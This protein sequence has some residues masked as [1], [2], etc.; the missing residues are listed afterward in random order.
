M[1]TKSKSVLVTTCVLYIM[2]QGGSGVMSGDAPVISVGVCPVGQPRGADSLSS[3]LHNHHLPALAHSLCYSVCSV[4]YYSYTLA[5]LLTLG[6]HAQLGL[7]SCVAS[8]AVASPCQILREL[9][10]GDHE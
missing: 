9:L 8:T 5:M 2:L 7:L 3:L 4:D 10:V 6:A 1:Y